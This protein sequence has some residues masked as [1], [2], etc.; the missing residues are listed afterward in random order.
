MKYLG[1]MEITTRIGCVCNC[2]YCPQSLLIANY[3]N[4]N[5]STTPP[6]KVMSLDTFKTCIDKLPE[7]TR[8]DFSGMAEPWLNPECTEMVLYAHKQGFP[9]AVYSTLVGMKEIDF[10]LI[11]DIPFEEFVLHIPDD[12]NNT[13]M[14]ITQEYL[15]LLQ[16]VVQYKCDGSSIVSGV[17]CHAGIHPEVK[18]FFSAD[19]KLITELHDRAGNV[20]SEYVES[21]INKGN[22]ICINCGRDMHHNVL[23]PDGTVLL[24]CMDY[25]MKHVLGNLI[26]QSYEEIHQSHEF[27]QVCEGLEN[28]TI[29]ILCRNCV[30]AKNISEVYDEYFLYKSWTNNLL[31]QNEETEKKQKNLESQYNDR[32]KELEE[33]KSWVANLKENNQELEKEQK[34]LELQYEARYKE[35][36]DY[37]NWVDNLK[38][39]NQKLR[40][41][42]NKLE[43]QYEARLKELNDYKNWVDSLKK[44]NEGLDKEH[45]NLESQY[46]SRLKEL[47]EYKNWVDKLDKNN[48]NLKEEYKQLEEQYQERIKEQHEYR[49]WVEN[50]QKQNEQITEQKG[51][52]EKCYQE[53]VHNVQVMQEKYSQLEKEMNSL[54]ESPFYK[55]AYKTKRGEQ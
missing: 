26:F 53:E 28:D 10:N 24:C 45:K 48:D 23:L 43:L 38:E 35:L 51:N 31:I 21:K 42:Q 50:L 11:K 19:S 52:L 30:N 13:H 29:D 27:K 55:L 39:N 15:E 6:Q 16:K 20:E 49:E 7:G 3:F 25:G 12:K 41:E 37:K 36:N 8:I 32:L 9:I 1:R 34:N 14:N 46:D 5:K 4:Q 47:S 44:R 33:Y 2:V 22:I 54:K 17:S 18:A 40:E